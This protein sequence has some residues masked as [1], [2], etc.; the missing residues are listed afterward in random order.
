MQDSYLA[1][2]VPSVVFV[3]V[4]CSSKLHVVVGSLMLVKFIFVDHIHIITKVRHSYLICSHYHSDGN[5]S[6]T[7][8]S[9]SCNTTTSPYHTVFSPVVREDAKTNKPQT[10]EDQ[11]VHLVTTS[12]TRIHPNLFVL[13]PTLRETAS[14]CCK[15]VYIGTAV[16]PKPLFV[17]DHDDEVDGDDVSCNV[18]VLSLNSDNG[19]ERSSHVLPLLLPTGRHQQTQNQVRHSSNRR[20]R[21]CH[22]Q[23]II[24]DTICPS[25]LLRIQLGSH[26]TSPQMGSARPFYS[27]PNPPVISSH[28]SFGKVRLSP[29]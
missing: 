12:I 9:V 17:L 7:I 22:K 6:S 14:Q 10:K 3:L 18:R 26:R 2:R 27:R 29:R 15:Q 21:R 16:L 8:Q 25:T 4:L 19:V 23:N 20:I 5:T 24:A 1:E 28:H 11:T 13:M